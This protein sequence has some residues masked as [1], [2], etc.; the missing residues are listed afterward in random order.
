MEPSDARAPSDPWIRPNASPSGN[1][2]TPR[3]PVTGRP[4]LRWLH[5]RMTVA[6]R[7]ECAWPS[8]G[9]CDWNP[10]SLH[11]IPAYEGRGEGVIIMALNCISLMT[12]HFEERLGRCWWPDCYPPPH[13]QASHLSRR[14]RGLDGL[15][16]FQGWS[17]GHRSRDGQVSCSGPAVGWPRRSSMTISWCFGFFGPVDLLCLLSHEIYIAGCSLIWDYITFYGFIYLV[18]CF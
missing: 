18:L 17:Q 2:L 15:A 16:R 1:S 14:L 13:S 6:A 11:A 10:S 7:G 3:S 4:A 5:D 12:N 9:V 8:S